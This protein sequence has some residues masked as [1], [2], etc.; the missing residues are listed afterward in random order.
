MHLLRDGRNDKRTRGHDTTGPHSPPRRRRN[1]H[2]A[3]TRHT[4]VG[5]K[6]YHHIS[7]FLPVC[8]YCPESGYQHLCLS[9]LYSKPAVCLRGHGV[10]ETTT[11]Q[12]HGGDEFRPKAVRRKPQHSQNEVEDG[13]TRTCDGSSGKEDTK[14]NAVSAREDSACAKIEVGELLV[15]LVAL[16]PAHCSKRLSIRETRRT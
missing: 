9:V 1:R 7:D 14:I 3:K 13:I 11:S 12:L 6:G 15:C 4:H 10:D 16:S 2:G 8:I 5:A